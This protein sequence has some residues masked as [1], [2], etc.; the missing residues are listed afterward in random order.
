MKKAVNRFLEGLYRDPRYVPTGRVKRFGHELISFVEVCH[1]LSPTGEERGR[2]LLEREFRVRGR[3]DGETPFDRESLLDHH[4]E[5]S[6]ADESYELPESDLATLMSESWDY[7]VRRNFHFLFG[8]FIAARNDAEH[9]LEIAALINRSVSEKQQR[10]AFVRWW[11][12]IE[13]DRAIAQA[14]SDVENARL[15]AAA[16]ELYRSM[17]AIAQY[18]LEHA[19]EYAHEGE[20]AV[21]MPRRMREHIGQL[22]ELLR[23]EYS[24]PVSLDQRLDDATSRGDEGEA[25]RIRREMTSEALSQQPDEGGQ[26]GAG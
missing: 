13:R 17:R 3:P 26:P 24:L 12:W 5:E 1:M 25:D 4:L 6:R 16:S 9:N 8:D 19:E 7:Y 14:L 15:D 11:P 21:A 20:E 18:S 22:V 2:V 10:W 23:R